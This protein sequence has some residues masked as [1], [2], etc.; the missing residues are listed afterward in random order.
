[1][2]RDVEIVAEN[3]LT[4]FSEPSKEACLHASRSSE[5]LLLILE[6]VSFR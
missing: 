2:L 6:I 4:S 3:F 1:M 5:V